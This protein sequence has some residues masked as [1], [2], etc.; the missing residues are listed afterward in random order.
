MVRLRTILTVILVHSVVAGN[1]AASE[2]SQVLLKRTII[3]DS[4]VGYALVLS[5]SLSQAIEYIG[6][7]P[8]DFRLSP[9]VC[10]T[11]TMW[12]REGT[13]YRVNTVT[14]HS[15]STPT[16]LVLQPGEIAETI[17]S[18]N[19]SMVKKVG[20]RFWLQGGADRIIAES[21]EVRPP[22]F[23]TLNLDD[24][25]ESDWFVW[26]PPMGNV[27]VGQQSPKTYSTEAA[28]GPTGDA[29]ESLSTGI[30]SK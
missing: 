5:N 28:D 23:R 24:P 21:E 2:M 25:Q 18:G 17:V 26:S 8:S 10:V 29:H 14:T 27:D 11:H 6:I 15:H 7:A 22:L 4:G 19:T 1:A 30:E 3:Q 9:E 20:I 13:W 16:K 12:L